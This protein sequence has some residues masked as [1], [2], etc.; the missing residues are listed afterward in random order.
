VDAVGKNIKKYQ[1]G[2]EVVAD[3]S[4]CGFGGWAEYIAIPEQYVV[5]KPV[6]VSF[7]EATAIPLAGITALCSLRDA[8]NIQPGQSVLINGSG[9]GVGTFAV[10]LAKYYGAEVTAVCSADNAEIVRSIGADH[11]IDYALEDFTQSGIQYDFIIAVNG[12]HPLSA[13][14]RALKPKGIYVM[15]GGTFPQIFQSLLFGPWMSLGSQKYRAL[16]SKANTADLAFLMNLL[17]SG[18]I[19]PVIDR[20]Y[21]LCDAPEAFRYINGGH[22]KGKVVITVIEE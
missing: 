21:P 7:I 5:Q 2:D 20:Q 18:K 1:I 8:C 22:A 15:V 10:Q 16:T 4:G 12:Y 14:K 19:H 13:Y 6:D 11:V 3:T 9:G 17:A